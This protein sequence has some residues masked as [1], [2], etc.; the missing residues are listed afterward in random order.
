MTSPRVFFLWL[1]FALE[2][3]PC[4]VY[5]E[6]QKLSNLWFDTAKNYTYRDQIL[7]L[8]KYRRVGDISRQFL[9]PQ[10]TKIR[11]NLPEIKKISKMK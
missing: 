1:G 11:H 5:F 4:R 8:M 7:N 9:R 10:D 2:M 6:A 3:Y